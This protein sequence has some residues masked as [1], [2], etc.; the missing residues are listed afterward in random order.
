MVLK[1]VLGTPSH[2]IFCMSLS[3]ATPNSSLADSTNELMSWIRCV[4]WGRHTKY[5]VVGGPQ[6]RFENHW[7]KG[8]LECQIFRLSLVATLQ[9]FFFFFG[10]KFKSNWTKCYKILCDR[11]K[12]LYV[13]EN[14]FFYYILVKK[15]RFNPISNNYT[16]V[17][18][19]TFALNILL[20]LTAKVISTI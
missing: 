18:A 19:Y 3:L 20:C 6:D 7:S 2:H 15:K 16:V 10:S 1:P 12:R 5:A 17:F 11:I 4:K 8:Q 14:Y 13:L 9:V